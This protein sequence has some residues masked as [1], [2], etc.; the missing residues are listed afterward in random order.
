MNELSPEVYICH[1]FTFAPNSYINVAFNLDSF[2]FALRAAHSGRC[3]THTMCSRV[4]ASSSRKKRFFAVPSYSGCFCRKFFSAGAARGGAWREAAVWNA[5]NSVTLSQDRN[6]D[7]GRT[8]E[9][10]LR[11]GDSIRF[12]NVSNT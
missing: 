8:A 11:Q 6:V 7:A 1:L 9:I 3:E 10:A 12:Q 5:R 4:C 2:T